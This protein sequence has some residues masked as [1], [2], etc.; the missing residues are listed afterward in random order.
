MTPILWCWPVTSEANVGAM[1][2][3]AEPLHQNS[4]PFSCPVTDG[5]RGAV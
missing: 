1:A 3:E 5:N 2:L 4:I